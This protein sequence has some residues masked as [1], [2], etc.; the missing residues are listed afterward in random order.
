MGLSLAVAYCPP[1]IA[2]MEVLRRITV[3]L[4]LALATAALPLSAQAERNSPVVVEATVERALPTDAGTLGEHRMAMSATTCL[5][6]CC[7]PRA[8]EGPSASVVDSFKAFHT[9]SGREWFVW[10]SPPEP[11]PPRLPFII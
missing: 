7:D 6:S 8:T 5:V 2:A 4:L 10:A 9:Y 11:R 1:I 3:M